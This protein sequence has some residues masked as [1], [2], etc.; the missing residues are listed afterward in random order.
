[1]DVVERLI[2]DPGSQRSTPDKLGL[3]PLH[4]AVRQ[5]HFHIVKLLVEDGTTPPGADRNALSHAGNTPMH[6]ASFLGHREIVQYLISQG[7]DCNIRNKQKQFAIDVAKTKEI[8]E[9][10]RLPTSVKSKCCWYLWHKN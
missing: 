8:G 7:A 2:R 6:L 9:I 1:M 5:R 3:T 4:E 10:L